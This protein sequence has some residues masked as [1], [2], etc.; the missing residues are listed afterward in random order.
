MCGQTALTPLERAGIIIIAH[1]V[2][3]VRSSL[4]DPLSNFVK[5][6]LF[7]QETAQCATISGDDRPRGVGMCGHPAH[8]PLGWSTEVA[9]L[10]LYITY[11]TWMMPE[12][13]SSSAS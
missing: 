7:E 8:T 6:P 4:L 12:D 5:F 10:R 9:V 1:T 13:Y 11:A 3:S 2:Q